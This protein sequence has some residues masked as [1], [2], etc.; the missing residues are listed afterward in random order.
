MPTTMTPM[1]SVQSVQAYQSR[2]GRLNEELVKEYVERYREG[3]KMD[4]I[5]VCGTHNMGFFI[6]DGHHRYEAMKRAGFPPEREIAVNV[7]D[8]R[9]DQSV[10]KWL[11][12]GANTAHGMRRTNDDKRRAVE[13]ALQSH[14]EQSDRAIAEHVG[15]TAPTVGDARKRVE[16]NCKNF[17]VDKRVGLDGKTRSVPPPPPRPPLP[18][19][20]PSPPSPAPAAPPRA[21]PV[22]P[23]TAPTPE[24]PRAPA[25]PQAAEKPS[26]PTAGPGE[27]RSK[28]A[29]ELNRPIPEDLYDHWVRRGDLMS[30]LAKLREIQRALVAGRRDR[31][32]LYA[33]ITQETIAYSTNV[34]NAIEDSTPYAVCPWCGGMNP[35]CKM[36]GN[37]GGFVSK[38][39]I[40]RFA[41]PD[42][43]IWKRVAPVAVESEQ[44]E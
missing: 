2:A 23:P 30:H 13:M 14:P 5:E 11:A 27:K 8:A 24:P 39:Q 10:V 7:A 4:P 21:V 35:G 25:A 42:P 38:F 33:Q 36:C 26:S 29:D 12:A 6:V 18:K 19:P 16:P 43:E 34:I 22:P 37:R 40:E 44:N 1:F 15:V 41:K 17:T 28:H 31:D 9:I 3:K 20:P 32:P